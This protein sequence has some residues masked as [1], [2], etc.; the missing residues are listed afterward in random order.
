MLNQI[1]NLTKHS[2]VYSISTFIQRFQGLVMLPIY[3][4]TSYLASSSVYGD[5]VLVY[6]F[7]AFMNVFYLYGLDAAFLRYYFIG[8]HDRKNI[9]RSSVQIVFFS[10]LITSTVIYLCATIISR[11]IFNSADYDFFIKIAAGILLLDTLCSLPYLILRAEEKSIAYTVIRIGRFFLEIILNI[12]F[13]VFLKLGVKGILYANLIAAFIN[14][15]VMIPF[16]WT[17]IRGQFS[18][19]VIKDLLHFGFPMIPNSLAYLLVDISDKW[20]MSRL[21]DK[22]TV[23]VYGVNYNLGKLMLLIIIAFRTAWQPFFLKISGEPDAKKIYAR[24]MT[25]F[26]AGAA[27]V[28][29]SGS[30]LVE[31]IVK[32]PVSPGKTLVG[33]AYWG[34]IK[35]IPIILLSYLCYGIYVNLTV[36]IYIQKK[37]QWMFLFTGLAALLNISSNFYLM[38]HYGI[39]GAAFATLLAYFIMMLSIF[40]AN[41]KFYPIAYEYKRILWISAYLIVCLII[42][43]L[44]KLD[45]LIRF[46]LIFLF[47]VVILILKLLK[48]EEKRYIKRF[49]RDRFS[50]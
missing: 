47:P 18:L 10:S 4:D 30:L 38:P 16:Q 27:F 9:Y 26:I 15:L 6:T 46:A 41:Q 33:A 24:I 7:I 35:I 48:E 50:S 44:W 23:G 25:Y 42:F 2:A 20:L 32:I 5:Y 13:V 45:I 19:A 31:Y 17:Y 40:I 29:I 43:Y 1:K 37:S 12:I 22:D 3:T 28:V 34:G 21:L 11:L 39:M 8:K 36:G 14:L 49:I